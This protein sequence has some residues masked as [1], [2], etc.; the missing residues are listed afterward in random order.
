MIHL[1]EFLISFNFKTAS[2][3]PVTKNKRLREEPFVCRAVGLK[4]GALNFR[5]SRGVA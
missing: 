2:K 1:D 4:T 3:N 5:R